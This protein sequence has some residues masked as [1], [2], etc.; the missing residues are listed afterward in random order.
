[1]AE[2]SGLMTLR[3]FHPA[4]HKAVKRGAKRIPVAVFGQ[5]VDIY[6][7]HFTVIVQA[8][9]MGNQHRSRPDIAAHFE[10]PD[11]AAGLGG[12]PDLLAVA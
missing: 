8:E 4:G 9:S 7:I 1:M 11:F 5:P 2:T 12:D 10:F 3:R 6:A